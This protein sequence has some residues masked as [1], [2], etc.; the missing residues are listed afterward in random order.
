MVLSLKLLKI[1]LK[2]IRIFG[3]PLI[4]DRAIRYICHVYSKVII[5]FLAGVCNID[6][7]LIE[8]AYFV[9]T[10]IPDLRFNDKKIDALT[11]LLISH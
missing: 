6:E 7:N 10:S 3:I 5:K 4:E 11:Y 2:W 9:D 1:I 8:S